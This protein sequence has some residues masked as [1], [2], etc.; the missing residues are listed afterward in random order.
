[1]YNSGTT[2]SP[3]QQLAVSRFMSRTYGWMSLGL[4]ITALVS[5]SVASSEAAVE[6]IIGNRIVF[7]GLLIAEVLLVMGLT[8]SYEKLSA[9]TATLGFIA[10][11][12]LNGV[13][14]SVILLVYTMASI[15][16]VFMISAGMF[17]GLALF[18][19][20]TRRDLTG[21]G[22]IFG[23]GIWGLILVGVANIFIQ[24]D[25]LSMGMSAVG[26]LVFAGL[27][28]Y[29]AQRIRSLAYQCVGTGENEGKGAVFGALS[30]YL[31]FINL[32]LS[33]LR[34]FGSKRS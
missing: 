28:A 19:T 6:M 34:L 26:V 1:M 4:L 27:T 12:A 31:N 2:S 15:G 32:F 13:T 16:Q 30:L 11:S 10:Y 29:D 33:L 17:G 14:L 9:R 23:M 8:A 3:T 21:M 5:F 24:S 20:V 18:G 25:A 22:A 7:Y